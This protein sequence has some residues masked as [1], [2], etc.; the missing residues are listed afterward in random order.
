MSAANP[1]RE[2]AFSTW[3]FI[4]DRFQHPFEH[5]PIPI[6]TRDAVNVV[7]VMTGGYDGTYF[8]EQFVAITD[9]R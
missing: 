3:P 9:P 1:F 2:I 8:C 5:P 6:F 4:E 7:D